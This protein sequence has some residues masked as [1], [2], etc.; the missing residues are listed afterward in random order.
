MRSRAKL[1]RGG[2]GIAGGENQIVK[3]VQNEASP[4]ALRRKTPEAH[5]L[6]LAEREGVL[7]WNPLEAHDAGSAHPCDCHENA[8]TAI[9]EL[10]KSAENKPNSSVRL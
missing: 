9:G 7:R 1:A 8:A 4:A 10:T 3:A 5:D 6:M 2:R